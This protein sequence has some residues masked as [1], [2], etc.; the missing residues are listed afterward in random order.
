ML[1]FEGELSHLEAANARIPVRPANDTNDDIGLFA[2]TREHVVDDPEIRRGR[3]RAE[4]SDHD[5][6]RFASLS[7][8]SCFG[9]DRRRDDGDEGI[10]ASGKLRQVL[11]L[12]R[13][14][15]GH[16]RHAR[17]PAPIAK[18]PPSPV[19]RMDIRHEDR[20][21]KVVDD[22]HAPARGES[23]EKGGAERRRFSVDEEHVESTEPK[24][25]PDAPKEP[26]GYR[27]RLF[28]KMSAPERDGQ[29]RLVEKCRQRHLDP[30]AT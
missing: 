16:R 20:F 2:G 8:M 19:R 14:C 7:G 3:L 1:S 6:A 23:L 17:R 4:P 28:E 12:D 11:V 30:E 5:R 9:V 29:A 24:D 22:R 27:R 26:A 10:P 21:V 15:R 13:N 18:P 25:V